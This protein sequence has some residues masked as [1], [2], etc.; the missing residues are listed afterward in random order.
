MGAFL[1]VFAAKPT[2]IRNPSHDRDFERA[3]EEALQDGSEDPA[4][5]EAR[6]RERYP[7][8]VIRPR[9]LD[10]ETMPT[11]YVYREGHWTRGD[12]AS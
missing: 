5:V 6:L 2:I 1:G 3:L 9:D 10:A 12:E 8:A 7:R 11:W 4:K